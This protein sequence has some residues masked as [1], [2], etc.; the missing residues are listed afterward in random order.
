MPK[1]IADVNKYAIL[2]DRTT[3]SDMGCGFTIEVIGNPLSVDD[4]WE[5][6]QYVYYTWD[7]SLLNTINELEQEKVEV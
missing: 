4:V 7:R 5:V 6:C 3:L 1:D 2:G